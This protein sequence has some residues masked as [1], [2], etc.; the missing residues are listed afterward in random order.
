MILGFKKK[1]ASQ[2]SDEVDLDLV[3]DEDFE[4]EDPSEDDEDLDDLK[5]KGDEWVAF[6]LSRDWREDGPFDLDEVDLSA[7]DEDVTRIDLG[8]LIITPEPD[9]A[10]KLVVD[11][12]TH[13]VLHLVVENTPT[14]AVQVTVYAA[15]A[16][17]GYTGELRTTLIEESENMKSFDIVEGPFGTEVRRILTLTDDQGKKVVSTIRDWFI[18]GPRWVLGVRLLGEAA[19]DIDGTGASANLKEFV[20]NI[21]VRRGD[22]A[23]APGAVVPLT[24]KEN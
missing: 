2:A 10:L 5:D 12:A 22:T 15:P 4:D 17:P 7:D 24:P 8:S 14:S 16:L 21:I 3:E 20:H 23:M 19:L 13:K 9:M 18:A 11:P 6:D 1:D